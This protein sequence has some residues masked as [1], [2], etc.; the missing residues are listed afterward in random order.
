MKNKIQLEREYK[1]KKEFKNKIFQQK[2]TKELSPLDTLN[3]DQ[4]KAVYSKHKHNLIIAS[5]GTG[6]TSTIVGRVV[7]L[8]Q[9][10]MKPDEIILL[11]FTSKAGK[12]MLERL[13]KH[14]DSNIV[15]KIFAGT[16]HSY[17]KMLMDK[18]GVQLKLKKQKD[19]ISLIS[20]LMENSTFCENTKE[21]Y[22]ASVISGYISL[23]ENT[24]SNETFSEWL[25]V[26]LQEKCETTKADNSI[27]RIKAQ[28]E[29]IESYEWLYKK[30]IN[31]K[32]IHKF[33]DFNDLLKY[34][35][36]Y[37]SKN[38]NNIK[39][40]I[41]DEYQDTNM[42]QNKILKT[43][44]DLGSGIF[45]VGDYDQSIYGFNGSNVDVVKEFPKKYK[46]TGVFT[47]SKNY[48]SSKQILE[49]ANNCIENNDRIIPKR[50]V[51]M[52]SG[53]FPKPT[54]KIYETIREQYRG[55]A[56][57]INS[58]NYDNNDIAI[59]FR[60]NN[61][62][63]LIEAILIEMGISTVRVKSGS[64][65]DGV[66]IAT[67]ISVYRII[68]GSATVLDFLNLYNYVGIDKNTCKEMFY[69]VK[70]GS[71][72]SSSVKEYV[73]STTYSSDVTVKDF[74]R[75]LEETEGITSPF[76]IFRIIMDNSC[77]GL[78]FDNTF[79]MAKRFNK[80]TEYAP[81]IEQIEQKHELLLR[82]AQSCSTLKDFNMKLTFSSKEEEGDEYGVKLL[83]VHAS[84][85][86][87]FKSV[88]VI[89][90][91]DE[92]FPNIKLANNG[93]GIEE[94]RRL[95]YVAVT[96]A[97]EHLV[98]TTYKVDD[99][100]KTPKTTPISRFIKESAII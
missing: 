22:S 62:G 12:E 72:K 30:Y 18:D 15:S 68:I 19:L 84:K 59:L 42:L 71:N 41:V 17:G 64:F 7:K 93:T 2:R 87:E 90:L 65:F 98:L 16:F 4:L 70:R 26:K 55:V 24:R 48:R 61:S 79:E 86:L 5:A 37:Y 13:K 53:V 88:Y 74:V 11:T 81:M 35:E 94:E 85:G 46:D 78:L 100:K 83:T 6:K 44:A 36:Y 52:K 47:L 32:K 66:D 28:I 69:A 75:L 92:K 76:T 67:M 77:Y 14:F 80:N 9:D 1:R 43:M 38:P 45:S 25:I 57:M 95:F 89:D 56:E 3:K 20:S 63:N 50:L 23:Y 73:K 10:G 91:S 33:C 58:S 49:L 82:I 29:T 60:S 96:R 27:N 51:A 54:L 40:I 8:L 31:E 39:Q 99:M 97:K 34:I 21:P